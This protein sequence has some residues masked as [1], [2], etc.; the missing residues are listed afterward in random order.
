[1]IRFNFFMQGPTRPSPLC[2]IHGPFGSGK[3]TVLVAM[4]LALLAAEPSSRVLVASATN[5]AVD[6]ILLGLLDAG[7]PG[8]MRLGS[9][10]RIDRRLLPHSLYC[11]EAK[12]AQAEAMQELKEMLAAAS[13]LQERQ[14]L[15]YGCEVAF[16]VF[17]SGI[18]MQRIML[19]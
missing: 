10:K 19:C 15:R 5:V 6:R 13:S 18:A 12:S 2:I 3:S 4:V 7:C 11:S 14:Q 1:M 8:L 9:L 17:R 16:A